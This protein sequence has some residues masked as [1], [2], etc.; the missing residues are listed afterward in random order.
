M[1]CSPPAVA[2]P[3][4]AQARLPFSTPDLNQKQKLNQ[5]HESLLQVRWMDQH[6]TQSSHPP[7]ADP[8]RVAIVP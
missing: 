8:A 2:I 6:T 3:A 1:V 7:D 5:A 4:D